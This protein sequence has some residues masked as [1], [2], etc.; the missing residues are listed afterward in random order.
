MKR[1][2]CLVV[3][4]A[5]FSVLSCAQRPEAPTVTY[6]PE[7]MKALRQVQQAALA[8]DYGL[9]QASHLTTNIG[10]RLSGS[11]QAQQAVEYMAAEL[12]RLG[13][14]VTLEK[15]MVPHWVRGE[16]DAQLIEFPGMAPGTTQ[17]VYVTALGGSV[18]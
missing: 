14:K 4:T 1:L 13:L 3:V 2:L 8:D 18:A 17:K 11:P 15:V 10:P 7:M 5:G 6:P 12:R 9:R 16:E